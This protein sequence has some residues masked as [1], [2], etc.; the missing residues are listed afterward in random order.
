[1]HHAT[2][3]SFLPHPEQVSERQGAWNFGR[4][5]MTLTFQKEVADRLTCPTVHPE[6]CRLSVLAQGY[7][8]T[9]NCFT[10]QGGSF[11]PP[12]DVDVG[13]VRLVPRI[14]PLFRQPFELVEKVLRCLFN[15]KRK[16]IRNPMRNLIPENLQSRLVPRL[17]DAAEIDPEATVMTLKIEDFSRICDVYA[18]F[19]RDIN[20]LFEYNHRGDKNMRCL[21][22]AEEQVEQLMDKLSN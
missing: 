9:K 8:H 15:T 1:M 10:I 19:C 17:L 21:W 12:P 4:T 6:R 5:T 14:E 13:V 16:Y 3:L 11:V 18:D 2:L 7:C 20:G 22:S